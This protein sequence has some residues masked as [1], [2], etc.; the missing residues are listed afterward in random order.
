MAQ[1]AARLG[2][3]PQQ[4]NR[5]PEDV[6]EELLNL[7]EDCY[8]ND[9]ALN[10]DHIRQLIQST[11][12]LSWRCKTEDGIPALHLAV[13]VEATP[14]EAMWEAISLLVEAGANPM[15]K[16]DDGDTAVDAIISLTEEDD[17]D[18]ETYTP[19]KFTH[20]AAMGAIL[21]S[22]HVV[23]DRPLIATLCSWLRRSMPRPNKQGK[24]EQWCPHPVTFEKILDILTSRSSR[25]DVTQ[26]W[27]SE[28]LLEYLEDCAYDKK[29]GVTAQKVTDFL[30]QGAKPGHMQ[31]GASSLLLTVLNP[32][33]SFAELE[34]VFRL[35]IGTDSGV[36]SIRDS[37]RLSPVQWAA[38]YVNVSSQHNLKRPN[39]AAYLALVPVVMAALPPDTDI[40]PVAGVACLKVTPQGSS[41]D[42]PKGRTI[43]PPRFLEGDR[44]D[45]CVETPGGTYDWEEGI[46][47][48]LWYREGCWPPEYPGAPYEVLLDLGQRVFAPADDDRLIRKQ[49][50]AATAPVTAASAGGA[51]YTF[52]A[53]GPSG[54]AK[55]KAAG[56]PRFIRRQR[57]DGKWEMF[58]SVSGRARLIASDSESDGE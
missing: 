1:D 9:T 15:E 47:I 38:D 56:A 42:G 34:Q 52:A 4:G 57:E 21:Q 37:F 14:A 41:G 48:A 44:V 49:G 27:C 53:T 58:D 32:Y 39:P 25:E 16:D 51:K 20:L 17:E 30:E 11:S 8:T 18:G 46:I 12:A 13:M 6:E 55:A 40:G 7:A 24:G 10:V 31:R 54:K 22:P 35:L 3:Y 33:S 43:T 19:T 29:C 5:S 28:E 23:V 45:C 36:I 26:A 2:G 50:T